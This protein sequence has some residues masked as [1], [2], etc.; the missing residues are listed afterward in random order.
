[1]KRIALILLLLVVVSGAAVAQGFLGPAVLGVGLIDVNFQ[2]EDPTG[3]LKINMRGGTTHYS[4]FLGDEIGVFG[5]INLGVVTSE[6]Q[7]VVTGGTAVA[8]DRVDLSTGG[9][10]LAFL[11]GPGYRLEVAPSHSVLF[12]AGVGYNALDY[13]PTGAFMMSAGLGANIEYQFELSGV[14]RLAAGFGANLDLLVLQDEFV[15]DPSGITSFVP[16]IAFGF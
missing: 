13:S 6:Q 11:V 15:G 10:V 5:R 9:L 12:A 8:G 16:Y 4:G 7:T 14:F 3:T 2:F 1:M